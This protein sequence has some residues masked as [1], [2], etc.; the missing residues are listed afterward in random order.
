MKDEPAN[1]NVLAINI[2]VVALIFG[3]IAIQNLFYSVQPE[4]HAVITRF[5]TIVGQSGPG[6]H[7]KLPFGI[8]KVQKVPTAR[9]LKQEFGFRTVPGKEGG[10]SSYVTAGYEEERQMLTGDLNMIEV[11]W[12]VQYNIEDP[13]KY[14]YQLQDAERVLREA[15][16]SVMRRI[17]GNRMSSEV[18]TTAR[19]DISDQ[20]RAEIQEAMDRYDSGIR[21]KPVELQDVL[22]PERVRPAFT[23]VNEARQERE[24]MSNEAM[25]QKNQAIPKARGEAK[26]IIAEAEAYAIE[27]VNR[28]K[29]EVARF[30]AILKEYRLAPEVTRK[31]LYLEAIQEV[32]PKAGKIIVVQE[33]YAKPQSFYHMNEQTGG[34]Q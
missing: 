17:V 8:D 5:G 1:T 13:V 34:T 11:S 31:R 16:E 29:G 30:D 28:A 19:V 10:P 6:L 9:V 21:I 20:A 7:F 24:R 2:L 33:G 26:R 22:P 4:E 15:S 14:L 27:R 3:G 18:L 32:A 12:V 23:E 25:K